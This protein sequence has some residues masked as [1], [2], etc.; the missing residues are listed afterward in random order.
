MFHPGRHTIVNI[1]GFNIRE[2]LIQVIHS[3]NSRNLVTIQG[4]C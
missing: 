2:Y 1:C 4:G 3:L